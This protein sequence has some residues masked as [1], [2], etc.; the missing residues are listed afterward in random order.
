MGYRQKRDPS[1]FED[2]RGQR[3]HFIVLLPTRVIQGATG[4][5]WKA[6]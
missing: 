4:K 2:Y 5:P 6:W 3:V 1:C